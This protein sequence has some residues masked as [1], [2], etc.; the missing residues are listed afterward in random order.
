[1]QVNGAETIA[2]L[3]GTQLT[4]DNE[5]ALLL[6][7]D[8]YGN[9]ID[10]VPH[11]AAPITLAL[12]PATITVTPVGL[13]I[14]PDTASV[15]LTPA[16]VTVTPVAPGVSVGAVTLALSPASV[17]VTAIGLGISFPATTT[18]AATVYHLVLGRSNMVGRSRGLRLSPVRIVK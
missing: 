14:T 7:G 6:A 13:G 10:V 16:M 9:L 4:W 15:A 2:V 18:A 12:T 8:A 5:L 3:D 11:G 1:M 17:T